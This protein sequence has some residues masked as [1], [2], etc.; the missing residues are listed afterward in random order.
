MRKTQSRPALLRIELLHQAIE[1]VESDERVD[2]NPQLHFPALGNLAHPA[3]EVRG[4]AQEVAPFVEELT[5]R[6]GQ[7][8]AVAAS[9]EDFD[10]QAF[11]EL[12]NGVS[13]R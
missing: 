6:F 5:P 9:V 10:P 8:R 11:L 13:D 7:H 2:R 3:F 4:G 12:S 1:F